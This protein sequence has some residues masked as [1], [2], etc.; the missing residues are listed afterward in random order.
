MVSTYHKQCITENFWW[1]MH[2]PGL[3]CLCCT[4]YKK[5]PSKAHNQC[6]TSPKE[7]SIHCI[8][9]L[10]QEASD[11]CWFVQLLSQNLSVLCFMQNM[12][13]HATMHANH[14]LASAH[15]TNRNIHLTISMPDSNSI[16]YLQSNTY[17]QT[18][19]AFFA[20][21]QQLSC[22]QQSVPFIFIYY[23]IVHKVQNTKQNV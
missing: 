17:K 18:G 13:K 1:L 15:W 14:C 23:K 11:K 22:I 8:A 2:C 21:L 5:R 7:L 16:K 4:L 10:G 3:T 12:S 6:N 19:A 20:V 9:V